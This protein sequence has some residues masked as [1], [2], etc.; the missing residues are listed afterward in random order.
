MARTIEL[1]LARLPVRRAAQVRT[2]RVNSEHTVWRAVHPNPKLLL[3]LRIPP[4][5][6]LRGIADLE[7]CVWFEK[8][9]RQ[10]KTEEGEK[11]SC[12]K[13]GYPS[14]YQPPPPL[15]DLGGRW[16]GRVQSG[17]GCSL[18]GSH[19]WCAHV[20]RGIH[21]SLGHGFHCIRIPNRL[22]ALLNRHESLPIIY[23]TKTPRTCE[24]WHITRP[25]NPALRPA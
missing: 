14:P 18:R 19:G 11:P 8:S 16:T 15:V 2:S 3:K 10:E 6:K 1:V 20:L 9:A 25:S 12:E 24:R 17:R 21:P 7:N 23:L 4:Q 22:F 5:G 13:S